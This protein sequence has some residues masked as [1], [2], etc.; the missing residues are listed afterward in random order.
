[1]FISR[2]K[3]LSLYEKIDANGQLYEKYV[4]NPAYEKIFP[5]GEDQKM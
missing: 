5:G 4:L 2:H 1:M 3:R